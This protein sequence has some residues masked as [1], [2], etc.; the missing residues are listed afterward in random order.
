MLE[1]LDAIFE[2]H[3]TAGRVAIEYRTEIYFGRLRE[4]SNTLETGDRRTGD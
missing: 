1:A 2:Q 4:E 3:A